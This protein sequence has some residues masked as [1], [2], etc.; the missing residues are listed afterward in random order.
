M[1]EQK[2]Y[3]WIVDFFHG[4]QLPCPKCGSFHHRAHQRVRKPII[5][6]KCDDCGTYF[7]VFTGTVFK[8]TKWP[9][10][11]VVMILR[12]FLKGD[13]TLSISKELKLSYPNLLYLR[14]K[15]MDNAHFRR[16]AELL[17]DSVTESDEVYQNAGEK[18]IPHTDPEDLP[19]RRANKKKGLAHSTTT[20]RPSM[21]P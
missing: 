1:N 9:C 3:E 4:G 19:R 12:G 21:A 15:L 16:E 18:G 11:K 10:S 7:N 2:C 13:S 5:Q 8:A 17:P 14:H 20:V 6:Y